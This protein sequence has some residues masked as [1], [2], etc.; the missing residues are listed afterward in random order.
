MENNA[1]ERGTGRS[2]RLM[3]QYI[4]ELFLNGEVIVVDHENTTN[5]N[6]FLTDKIIRR[7]NA[8]HRQLRVSR[9]FK[10]G[11]VKISII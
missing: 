9:V 4:Q 6:M 11:E 2:T 7:L 10:E 1:S 3:D 5:S 8:E